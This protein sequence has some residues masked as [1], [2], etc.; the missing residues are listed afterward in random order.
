M[1]ESA[2]GHICIVTP[3]QPATNPRMV[4]EADALAGAGYKV[5]V[6]CG[7]FVDWGE[8]VRRDFTTRGWEIV[9]TISFGQD[10]GV[11]RRAQR[12]IRVAVARRV[13]HAGGTAARV[14]A[15]A[16]HTIG[17]ELIDTAC[18]CKADLYIAHYPA[19]LPAAAIAATRRGVRYAFDAEDFHPG[20]LPDAPENART[21]SLLRQIES[22]YLPGAAFVTAAAPLI[23]QAY[24]KEY[25]IP[26][27]TV[28]LNTFPSEHAPPG[29]TS[30]GTA[31]PGPSL[32]WFSQTIGPSRGLET[33]VDAIALAKSR[34]HLYLRGRPMA[35]YKEFLSARAAE[36]GV[37]KR[38][39]WLEIAPPTKM[40]RLAAEYDVGLAGEIGETR[41]RQFALTNK[42]FTYTLA[43]I[44]TLMSDI[45]A[46]REIANQL[47]QARQ[48]YKVGNPES[49]AECLDR[50][51]LDPD[52]LKRARENAFRCGQA[53]LNWEQDRVRL[54]EEV[55]K[56]MLGR[57]SFSQPAGAKN[58]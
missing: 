11:I 51:L 49:L 42:L 18:R 40:V 19:A 58:R 23:A 56:V 57:C 34:P 4:K 38:I 8:D 7:D 50:W 14:L 6:I 22:R 16:W 39:H 55:S 29:P 15:T 52:T 3:G 31:Q 17:P 44:P 43:G 30:A 20:D 13:V 5:S 9:D 35:G 28:I 1:P 37:N 12:R 46:H 54:L 25:S 26:L 53:Q 47:G 33:A 21:N 24:A 36:R 48:L 32:Y 27:P 10:S 45:P 41:N 2:L